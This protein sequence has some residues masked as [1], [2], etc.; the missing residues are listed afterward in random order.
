MLK[1][2]SH[3]FTVDL[4]LSAFVSHSHTHTLSDFQ[5]PSQGYLNDPLLATLK[6]CRAL[7]LCNSI[8]KGVFKW[9]LN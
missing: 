8:T 5:C 9:L 2:L 1:A 6:T 4:C 7:L 3:S